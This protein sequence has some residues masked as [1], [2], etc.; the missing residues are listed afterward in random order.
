[1]WAFGQPR[2]GRGRLEGSGAGGPGGGKASTREF[3]VS[4]QSRVQL[5]TPQPP[6]SLPLS[7]SPTGWG[8]LPP[9]LWPDGSHTCIDRVVSTPACAASGSPHPEESQRLPGKKEEETVSP[10]HPSGPIQPPHPSQRAGRALAPPWRPQGGRAP[11]LGTTDLPAHLP[12]RSSLPALVRPSAGGG[13][14]TALS[15]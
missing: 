4:A 14:G 8:R 9:F 5:P 3:L 2:A 11:G 15:R 13:Q 6:D 1:M 7:P 10:T 12:T